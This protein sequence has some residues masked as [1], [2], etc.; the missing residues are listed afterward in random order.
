LAGKGDLY[1]ARL[2]LDGSRIAFIS[3]AQFGTSDPPGLPQVFIVNRDG[4]QFRRVTN[5][6]SGVQHFAYSGDGRVIWYVSGAGQLIRQHLESGSEI[7]KIGRT[8]QLD[9]WQPVAAAG[10][11]TVLNGTGFGPDVRVFVDDVPAP[12]LAVTPRE[13]TIQAPWGSAG[14]RRLRVEGISDASRWEWRRQITAV[15]PEFAPRIFTRPSVDGEIAIAAHEDWR[16]LATEQDP[17]RPGEIIHMYGTGFGPVDQDVQTSEPAPSNP[18]ARIT[19]LIVC[20]TYTADNRLV[21]VP[22][23]FAG[24]APETIGLYQI[25]VQI[26]REPFRPLLWLGC[27]DAGGWLPVGVAR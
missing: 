13:L 7:E 27:G 9:E 2:S 1:H 12:V 25:S 23:V 16:G 8:L 18:P 24:L 17:V 15:I 14:A 19:K 11:L 21:N 22:V 20:Q 3:T 6:P 4:S 10:S 5:N 26:P